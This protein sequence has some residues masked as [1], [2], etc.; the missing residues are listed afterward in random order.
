VRTA[1]LRGVL[2]SNESPPF[3]EEGAP[4]MSSRLARRGRS[5]SHA[6]KTGNGHRLPSTTRA[7]RRR[8]LPL[9]VQK[10]AAVASD[11]LQAAPLLTQERSQCW[12]PA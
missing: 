7:R 11:A 8:K 1:L 5:H 10:G 6:V 9:D 12:N 2:G 3:S 4:H